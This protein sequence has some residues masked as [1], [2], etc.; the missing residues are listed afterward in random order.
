M[1]GVVVE[2]L[3]QPLEA[4]GGVVAKR[5]EDLGDKLVGGSGVDLGQSSDRVGVAVL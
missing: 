4:G 5:V 1:D 2:V 3:A